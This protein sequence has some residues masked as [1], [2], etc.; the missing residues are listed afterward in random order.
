M[1]IRLWRIPYW[2]GTG[3]LRS[4]KKSNKVKYS[5]PNL[6]GSGLSNQEHS[7]RGVQGVRRKEARLRMF[8]LVANRY[9]VWPYG[10]Q[11]PWEEDLSR[12]VREELPHFKHPKRPSNDHQSPS[13]IS[14]QNSPQPKVP[15][16]S[17][18][19]PKKDIFVF[20]S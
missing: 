1:P 18:Q 20:P 11:S 5:L 6:V 8:P 19:T 9:K 2:K 14:S 15:F 17:F 13:R 4:R 10:G 3:H 12:E 7:L 16:S